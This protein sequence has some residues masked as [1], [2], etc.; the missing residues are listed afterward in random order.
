ME[1]E[2]SRML[3]TKEYR[4][5]ILNIKEKYKEIYKEMQLILY[6]NL[7]FILIAKWRFRRDMEMGLC[8]VISYFNYKIISRSIQLIESTCVKNIQIVRMFHVSFILRILLGMN[9]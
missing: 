6:A 3:D 9:I 8:T 5:E 4:T 7:F 1:K 2:E